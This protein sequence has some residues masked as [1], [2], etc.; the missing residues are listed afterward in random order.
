MVGI[1][2]ACCTAK[3]G[4]NLRG[5]Q[6]FELLGKAVDV[7]H[8]FLSQTRR[9]CRLPVSLGQHRNVAP[10][11]GILLQ[12]GDELFHLRIIH[13]VQGFLQQQR[14]CGVVD[15]L[16]GKAKMDEFL[17]RFQPA[18]LVK[19][20]FQEIFHGLDIM[21]RHLFD[22]LHALCM[23]L[24]KAAIDVAQAF[25]KAVVKP[26]KLRK[27]KLTKAYEILNLNTD[28]IAYERIFRK[29]AGQCLCLVTITAIDR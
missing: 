23:L 14:G 24:V 13:L 7:N 25:K 15:I 16:R 4:R 19:L 8:H 18:Y 12:L 3:L 9:R 29:I 17:E 28:T 6:R 27:R 2:I 20:L 21:V 11:I 5:L 26:F 10:L 22:V 1:E